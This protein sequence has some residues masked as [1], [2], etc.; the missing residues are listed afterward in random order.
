MINRLGEI[1]GESNDINYAVVYVWD[2]ATRMSIYGV[3]SETINQIYTLD[4]N[5]NSSQSVSAD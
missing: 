2:V 3:V 4:W 1:Y 5:D